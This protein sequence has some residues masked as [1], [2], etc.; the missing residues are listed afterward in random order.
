MTAAG[1]QYVLAAS[2]CYVFLDQPASTSAAATGHWPLLL[3]LLL[4]AAGRVC[5]RT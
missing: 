4:Q 1:A 2:W 5:L 3:L